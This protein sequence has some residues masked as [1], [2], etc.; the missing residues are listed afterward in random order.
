VYRAAAFHLGMIDMLDELE[1]L[2]KVKMLSTAS[3]GT[4]F[5]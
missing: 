3:G 4:I 1:M 2:D 5:M